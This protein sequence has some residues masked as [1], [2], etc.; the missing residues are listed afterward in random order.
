[1]R[2]RLSVG[3]IAAPVL[4]VLLGAAPPRPGTPAP[5]SPPNLI[6]LRTQYGLTPDAE[7]MLLR[8]GF[9]VLDQARCKALSDAYPFQHHTSPMYVTTDAMLELW[10]SLNR[11]LLETTERQVCIKQLSA[12]LPALETRAKTLYEAAHGEQ[13]RNALR[14]VS[15]TVGVATR[16]LNSAGRHTTAPAALRSEIDALV[17]KV[18]A[19]SEASEYPGEDYT[20]YTVRGHYA[21]DPALSRYFQASMWLSRRFF[22]VTPEAGGDPNAA[23]RTAVACAAVVR[24]AGPNAGS[25]LSGL[26]KLR[27]ALA[28]RPDAVS[29]PQ[30]VSALDRSVGAGWK[31]ERALLPVSL[32]AL[33]RELVRPIYPVGQ[34]RTRIVNEQGAPFPSQTVALLPGLASPDSMLFRHTV[35]PAINE[36]SLPTGL[37][38]A[39]SLGSEAARREIEQQEGARSKEVLAAVDRYGARLKA[40]DGTTIAS[41]WLHALSTLA[42]VPKGAPDFMRSPAWQFEKLNTTLAGWAQIRHNYLLYSE[43]N[44]S[45]VS[46]LTA[47]EP[48][49][50][51]PNPAFYQ[52]MAQLAGRTRRILQAAGGLDLK[53][54]KTLAAYETKCREF[55]TYASAELAGTLTHT[56]SEEIDGFCDWL[57]KVYTGGAAATVAD[58]ATGREREVLHV[59]T[60]DMRT[61]L[62]IPDPK[63]GVVYTGAVLSY[64][65]FTRRELD[66]LTDARWQ[67]QQVQTYLRPEPPS[68]SYA[69]MAQDAGTE[70]QARELLRA[71]EKLL[72]ANRGEE[73]LALLRTTVAKNPDTTLATE[74]QCR[75]GRY[76]FDRQELAQ[77]QQELRRCEH[78]PGCIAFDQAQAMLRQVQYESQRRDYEQRVAAP[79]QAKRMAEFKRLR[80]AVA[81]LKR[82][83]P[84]A[85]RE[86]LL[87]QRLI[88][89]LPWEEGRVWPTEVKIL[90]RSARAVCRTHPCQDA[91]GYVLLIAERGG[92]YTHTSSPEAIERELAFARQTASSPLRAAMLGLALQDGYLSDQPQAALT[93]LRPF[94]DAKMLT[95]KADPAL[96]L[97]LT[98]PAQASASSLVSS[99]AF[100]HNPMD[101][102]YERS[103][104]TVMAL[105][106]AALGAGQIRQAVR[107]AR[108][109]PAGHSEI[110]YGD[111]TGLADI[112]AY[113]GAIPDAELPAA[114]MLA[115][116]QGLKTAQRPQAMADQALALVQRYPHSRYAL[117]ALCE[118]L[119]RMRGD[120][121]TAQSSR[122]KAALVRDY[123]NT[124]PALSLEVEAVFEQGDLARTRRLLA[125]YQS[126]AKGND[127]AEQPEQDPGDTSSIA[128][129]LERYDRLAQQL[130]PLLDISQD[131][132][133]SRLA[134]RPPKGEPLAEAIAKRMPNHAAEIYRK[135]GVFYQDSALTMRFLELS[136]AD[137]LAGDA[138]KSLLGEERRFT[139][140]ALN[141]SGPETAEWL[142]TFVNRNDA[143][144]PAA[145][146]L[147][148]KTVRT[149][150]GESGIRL[151]E[152]EARLVE[153]RYPQSRAAGVAALAVA[154]TLLVSHRPEAMLAYADRASA[155]LQKD[156]PLHLEAEQQRQR[157]MLEIAAK[158]QHDW[159][160][161]W[162]TTLRM[163]EARTLSD[164]PAP[165]VVHGLLLASEPDERG[166][167]QLVAMETATGARRW[168]SRLE[169]PLRDFIAPSGG[170][171]V[172]CLEENG[173]VVALDPQTGAPLWQRKVLSGQ[174][175]EQLD[176]I[177]GTAQAIVVYGSKMNRGFQ[178]AADDH[179]GMIGLSPQDGRPLW[180]HPDWHLP[181]VGRTVFGKPAIVQADIVVGLDPAE[182]V[183]FQPETGTVLWKRAYPDPV[184]D[185]EPLAPNARP[186]KR[187]PTLLFQ[188]QTFEESHVMVYTL[189]PAS[190]Y[191][192]LEGK[193]D[194]LLKTVPPTAQQ[195]MPYSFAAD[196][197]FLEWDYN[198]GSS[199]RRTRD[200]TSLPVR[201]GLR[202]EHG[203]L[204]IA[205]HLL[206]LCDPQNLKLSAIDLE[207]GATVAAGSSS[208]ADFGAKV[209]LGEEKVFVVGFNGKITAFPLF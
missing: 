50:V 76:Y 83:A 95:D 178:R 28:G 70:W 59:A 197:Y 61:L 20:Q 165:V 105:A 125:A 180:R 10:S 93:L 74:A 91:L 181:K 187:V 69:F 113:W 26:L 135:L 207:T 41:G 88:G 102:F 192:L 72:V 78:L 114:S 65:E 103:V 156:D 109:Y 80:D 160:P 100:R 140:G 209:V 122:L 134:M 1:M 17:Q 183:A 203:P 126:R 32:A 87:T 2:Y 81:A 193:T 31:L 39:A 62:V 206:Y 152:E 167:R 89:E 189:R 120:A 175:G 208:G 121:K 137:P 24:S 179:V 128:Y 101:P 79:A 132:E 144:S 166:V 116:L 96:K 204:A 90:L 71:A 118:T 82:S 170:R 185:T 12:F 163:E 94:L 149:G 64:Y 173:M 157:A 5:T 190:H 67:A 21:D 36:R 184:P 147:L 86:R 45:I 158:H 139:S 38:V 58:V 106:S 172:A 16:L 201:V 153:G 164:P 108:L 195:G 33:R 130:K 35:H 27:E 176:G 6:Q 123:P 66:R 111:E 63:T 161:L 23:L 15:V 46:G 145:A 98:P 131:A 150:S 19:H 129:W 34:V 200:F 43:Q 202:Q 115:V 107:Y 56:Q 47:S 48:A 119:R 40:D 136:P 8:N 53:R 68:W 18:R 97:V 168:T 99:S 25:A 154:E 52:A 146:K 104:N 186:R 205:A 54:A 141:Q 37:E 60:G 22:A 30:L 55:A 169:S 57:E 124:V 199:V 51:E 42:S 75:L 127:S 198:G 174:E 171:W 84:D 44:Y 138:W 177:T 191:E 110:G 14:Q 151:A 11:D 29:L 4:I 92:R 13:E 182:V 133:I 196:G 148:L 112:I 143:N 49:L 155:L 7:A 85:G 142:A 73:A 162:E 77:A 159:R 3:V 188:P 194:A 9:L 117:T